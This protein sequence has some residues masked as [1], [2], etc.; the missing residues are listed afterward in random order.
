LLQNSAFDSKFSPALSLLFLRK[1][2]SKWIILG[3]TREEL[4]V[5][6]KVMKPTPM[7]C[8]SV[9]YICTL[10]LLR[11]SIL[12]V[13][14]HLRPCQK[15]QLDSL[16]TGITPAGCHETLHAPRYTTFNLAHVMC[17]KKVRKCRTFVTT[18]LNCSVNIL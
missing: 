16:E 18:G 9:A 4:K 1:V 15:K 17:G 2:E 12:V 14:V 8:C 6:S 7:T 3:D 13:T 10:F 5:V 11:T